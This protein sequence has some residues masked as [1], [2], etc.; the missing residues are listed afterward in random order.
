M[1]SEMCIRDR[2]QIECSPDDAEALGYLIVDAMEMTTEY[3]KLNCPI[4]GDF[5]IGR[6]WNETH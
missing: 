3:Y 2:I 5:K 4:T 1:G 6:S